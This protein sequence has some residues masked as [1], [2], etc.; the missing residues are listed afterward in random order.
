MR[1]MIKMVVVLTVLSAASGGLLAALKDGTKDAIENQVLQNEKAPALHAIFLN[2]SNDP[3]E[4]R[5]KVMDGDVER[6]VF[7]GKYDGEPKA[8]AFD[9]SGSGYGGDIGVIVGVNIEKDELIGVAV[10]THK[11]T[12][13]LGARAKTDKTFIAQFK[14]NAIPDEYAVKADGGNVDVLSGATITSR[15]VA[16]A[17]TRAGRIYE[18]IKPEI[19]ENLKK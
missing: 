4:D 6:T 1:D 8:V 3:V 16:Q 13:G 15:G 17:V 18:R 12:P 11:E 2:V 5:F 9:S 10:T 19:L 7:I 14:G